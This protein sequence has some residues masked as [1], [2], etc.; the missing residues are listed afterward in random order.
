MKKYFLLGLF[1]VSVLFALIENPRSQWQPQ[2][3]GTERFLGGIYFIDANTGYITGDSSMVLKTT[4]GGANWIMLNTGTSLDNYFYDAYFFNANTGYIC[5]GYFGGWDYG[6]IMMTTNGGVNW[7]ELYSGLNESL[8]SI[9]FTNNNT[10][11][12]AGFWGKM[13]KTTNAGTNWYDISTAS[14]A[15]LWSV[16]FTSANTGYVAGKWGRINKT[17]NAGL[18]WLV[19]P[20]GTNQRIGCL[21]F[22][23]PN[24]GYAVG[25]SQVIIKTTNGGSNW[26]SQ[27]TFGVLGYE[28]VYFT[29]PNTGYIVGNEWVNPSFIIKKTSNAGTNWLTLSGGVGNPLFD[30]FFINENTGW[31]SGYLGTIL[32]TTNGGT[33][34]VTSI[35]SDVPGSF[36]LYQNYPNPFNP[37]T[38]IRFDVPPDSRFRGNDYVVLKIYDALGKD[39]AVLVNQQL[40]PGTYEVTWNASGFPSGVYF[41]KLIAG[42]YTCT[43]KLVLIK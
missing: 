41:Y 20:S 1:V 6:K 38:K 26:F 33:T 10:G 18:N 19:L 34:G 30:V 25:D 11:Y 13:L 23:D 2:T 27:S 28:S 40:K 15:D 14:T 9:T 7:T 21:Y 42:N 32:H 39:I 36:V 35:S 22:T 12:C 37:T 17:T 43:K 4:N 31:I 5:G 29:S 24:T 16:V 3:S 8:W